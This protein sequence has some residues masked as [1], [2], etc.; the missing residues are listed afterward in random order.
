MQCSACLFVYGP[1]TT[2]HI[3]CVCVCVCVCISMSITVCEYA[4]H[5]CLCIS[6]GMFV[7]MHGPS[8]NMMHCVCMYV[9]MY[10]C[11]CAHQYVNHGV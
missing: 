1:S 11:V 5:V 3:V 4:V 2:G 10:V 8:R 9:C 7:S 6:V